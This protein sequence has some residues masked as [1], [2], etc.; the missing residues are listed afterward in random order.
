MTTF[1]GLIPSA[2]SQITTTYR[3]ASFKYGNGY[4]A[5]SPDGP[6]PTCEVG[7]VNFDNITSIQFATLLAWITANPPYVTW[8]GDGV[9]L[10]SSKTYWI[11]KDGW[12][13]QAMPGNIYSVTL[14]VEQT[15]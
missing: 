8:L 12:Q 10:S 15:Y 3:I 14:N 13:K 7:Q 9:L 6:N 2:T 1:G 5:R 11:N 4:E